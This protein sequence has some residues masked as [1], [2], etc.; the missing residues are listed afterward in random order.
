[1]PVLKKITET[2]DGEE[3]T[4]EEQ[5]YVVTVE[6]GGQRYWLR[7]TTFAFTIER[8]DGFEN[9]EAAAQ[10]LQKASKY[11]KPAMSKKCV[12][13]PYGGDLVAA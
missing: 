8:A 11:I 5:V 12:I 4:M 10:A 7:G 13:V 1:M 3:L 2:V 9:I 6:N